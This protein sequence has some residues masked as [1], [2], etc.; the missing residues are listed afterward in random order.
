MERRPR[1]PP[2]R[3]RDIPEVLGVQRCRAVRSRIVRVKS[4]NSGTDLVARDI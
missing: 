2:G 4:Q 1:D 3:S